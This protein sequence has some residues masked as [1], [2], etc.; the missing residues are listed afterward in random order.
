MTKPKAEER[1]AAFETAGDAEP[2]RERPSPGG[3]DETGS[4]D[5]TACLDMD[6]AHDRAS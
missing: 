1:D 2:K 6:A 5:E 3:G 4:A